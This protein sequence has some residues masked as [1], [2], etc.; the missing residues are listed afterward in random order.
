M[1]SSSKLHFLFL[2]FSL[3][4]LSCD[5]ESEPLFEVSGQVELWDEFADPLEDF[6]EVKITFTLTDQDIIA[7]SDS[8]GH[9]AAA[10][11]SWEDV[12]SV[13]YEKE[14]FATQRLISNPSDAVKFKVSLIALSTLE[15]SNLTAESLFSDSPIFK[16]SFDV[17]NYFSETKPEDKRYFDLHVYHI[18]GQPINTSR[19]FGFQREIDLTNDMEIEILSSTKA[20]L[21]YNFFRVWFLEDLSPNTQVEFRIYGATGSENYKF[22]EFESAETDNSLNENFGS[23]IVSI[24]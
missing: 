13:T 2:L 17:E 10:I 12:I 9:F 15:V 3:F 6:S 16:F 14:G 24:K 20:R 4:L 1:N 7:F 5:T 23:T 22:Y 8:E 21:S 19:F 18:N 11:S